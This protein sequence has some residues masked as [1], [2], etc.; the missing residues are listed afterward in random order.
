MVEHLRGQPVVSVGCGA[1]HTI[2]V[3]EDGSAYSCGDGRD[4]KLGHGDSTCAPHPPRPARAGPRGPTPE[5]R[6]LRGARPRGFARAARVRW[7]RGVG[8]F[9]LSAS[10]SLFGR[11][12]YIYPKHVEALSEVLHAACG[13]SHSVAICGEGTLYVWGS[14]SRGQ[15]GVASGQVRGAPARVQLVRGEGR[16]V[17]N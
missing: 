13:F 12:T 2:F 4:G 9:S 17:S 8:S 10:L 15:L 7:A 14:A 16:S 11:R 1:K 5:G 3:C 6:S